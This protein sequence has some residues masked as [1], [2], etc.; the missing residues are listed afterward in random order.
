MVLIAQFICLLGG[1]T[2]NVQMCCI[3]SLSGSQ[4]EWKSNYCPY[5]SVLPILYSPGA[6]GRLYVFPGTSHSED[7][8]ILIACCSSEM[9]GPRW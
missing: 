5:L 3:S 9:V 7:K 1:D 6:S 2:S 8:E 4:A